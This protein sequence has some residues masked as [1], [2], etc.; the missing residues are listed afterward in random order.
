MVNTLEAFLYVKY[1]SARHNTTLPRCYMYLRCTEHI[2]VLIPFTYLYLSMI[3][4]LWD[5]L[6]AEPVQIYSSMLPPFI[7]SRCM[8]RATSILTIYAKTYGKLLHCTIQ[9]EFIIISVCL[10]HVGFY[11][12]YQDF[13]FFENTRTFRF[14]G[15]LEYACLLRTHAIHETLTN[16]L[17][18]FL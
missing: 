10:V 12:R 9:F 14:R 3:T 4:Q 2:V 6:R 8:T 5:L 11:W 15:F 18:V 17:Y 1:T 16:H 7:S 13:S